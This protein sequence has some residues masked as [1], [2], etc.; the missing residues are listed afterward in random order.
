MIK[1]PKVGKHLKKPTQCPHWQLQVGKCNHPTYCRYR[2]R[3][4]NN[5]VEKYVTLHK[6]C[7]KQELANTVPAPLE[8]AAITWFIHLLQGFINENS[9]KNKEHHIFWSFFISRTTVRGYVKQ[10]PPVLDFYQTFWIE[11]NPEW[12]CR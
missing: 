4:G 3:C 12:D 8:G 10:G 2:Y 11:M 9:G 1:K 7:V 6:Y 5:G